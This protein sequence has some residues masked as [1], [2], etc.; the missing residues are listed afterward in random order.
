MRRSLCS[1]FALCPAVAWIPAVADESDSPLLIAWIAIMLV[2]LI[3][4][5]APATARALAPATFSAPI[6]FGA[7]TTHLA[8]AVGD[9]NG[10]TKLDIA[11]A[12][13]DSANVSILLGNGSGGFSAASNFAAHTNPN[14]VA[15]GE[16]DG[17]SLPDLAVTN[18]N[19][20]DISILKGL[21]GGTFSAPTNIS[22]GSK[23]QSI[24]VGKIFGDSL[25][26]LAVTYCGSS[27]SGT[28]SAGVSVL[29]GNGSGG[30][31]AASN[32]AAQTYPTSVAIGDLNGDSKSDVA[33]TNNGSGD[34][35]ILFGDGLGGFSAPTNFSAHTQPSAL[36]IA[37]L[38]GDSRRDLIVTNAFSNDVSIFLQNGSGGLSGPVNY[39]TGSGPPGAVAVADLNGDLLPDLAVDGGTLGVLLGTGSG[40]F[41]APSAFAARSGAA[42]PLAISAGDFNSDGRTDLVLV[43]G[44]QFGQVYLL[45]NLGYPHPQSAPQI[46]VALVPAFRQCGTP[47]NS[48]NSRHATPLSVGS[49]DPPQPTSP[50]ARTGNGGTDSAT[51]TAQTTP[52]SDVLLNVSDSDIETAAGADYDPNGAAGNDLSATFRLRLTDLDNCAPSPCSGS[53][54]RLATGTDTDFPAVPINCVPNGSPSAPPGSDCNTSTSANAVAPGSVVAGQQAVWNIFRVRVNDSAGNLFQQQ[55]VFAP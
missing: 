29:L 46:R 45:F 43:D 13:W 33:V 3:A 25:P 10:D 42:G 50:S 21:G 7:L 38:N 24:A 28:G 30:F 48:T 5:F 23:P 22:V 49:C 12:N 27:C 6:G 16:F 9:L 35:S 44:T 8:V 26:D 14:A 32:F 36:A 47:A 55:G 37:D 31:S 40:G 15:V 18:R 19:S 41:Y 2:A 54:T 39:T 34:V 17:D 1:R 4:A 11:V 20:D 51:M 53:Y 52:T